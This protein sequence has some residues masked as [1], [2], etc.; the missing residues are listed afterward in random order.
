LTLSDEGLEDW[1]G[2]VRADALETHSH[3]TVS[4]EFW[5][6]K[7]LALVRNS[8]ESLVGGFETRNDH[9]IGVF[10]SGDVGIVAILNREIESKVGGGMRSRWVIESMASATAVAMLAGKPKITAASVEI[11]EEFDWRSSDGD[12]ADPELVLFVGQRIFPH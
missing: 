4:R 5:K 1:R 10:I 2:I 8:A 9:I 6:T 11:D 3:E 7:F 12:G